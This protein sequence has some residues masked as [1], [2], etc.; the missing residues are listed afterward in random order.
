MRPDQLL[1]LLSDLA[2]CDACPQ[3]FKAS[4]WNGWGSYPVVTAFMVPDPMLPAHVAQEWVDFLA[5]AAFEGVT[6]AQYFDLGQ[7]IIISAMLGGV[8]WRPV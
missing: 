5:D 3:G 6:R 2:T 7:E 8:A 4:P 1:P